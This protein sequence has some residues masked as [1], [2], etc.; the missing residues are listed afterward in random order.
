[1]TLTVFIVLGI[2]SALVLGILVRRLMA[3]PTGAFRSL[4]VAAVG[5]FALVP[6]VSYAL[7]LLGIDPGRLAGSEIVP[8]VMIALLLF[9]WLVLIQMSILLVI[10]LIIPTGTLTAALRNIRKLPAWWRRVRR[11]AEIQRILLRHGLGSYAKAALPVRRIRSREIAIALRDA[12]SAAGVTFIKLGQFMA[13]RADLVPPAYVEQ[14]K[15]LQADVPP[16]P[17]ENI[18]KVLRSQWNRPIDEVFAWFERTP[19][20]AASVAQVHRAR[21]FDGHDVVVKVQRPSV[22]A[23]VRADS[24]IILTLADR[25]ERSTEWGRSLGMRTIAEGFVESLQEELD[26]RGEARNTA[27]FRRDNGRA[28]RVGVPRVFADLSGE[29]VLVL[30]LLPGEPLTKAASLIESLPRRLRSELAEELFDVVARQILHTGIFHADLHGGNILVDK[31]GRTGLIDFGAVGR[32]DTRD[33]RAL[34]LLLMSFDKQNA[35]AATAALVDLLGA[36]EGLNL[37]EL[38][39]EVGQILMRYSS[40]LGESGA[41]SLFGEL[42]SFVVEFGLSLPAPVA[43]AFRAISALEGSLRLI[44]PEMDILEAVRRK[45]MSLMATATS[46]QQVADEAALYM[47]ANVPLLMRLPSKIAGLATQLQD[48]EV[49]VAPADFNTGGFTLMFK[50]L[51]EQL[52][53][54]V[55]AAACV[56]A[57]VLLMIPDFGPR[58]APEMGLFTYFGSLLLLV[59]LTL[60]A[61]VVS[62]MIGDRRRR[63]SQ[64]SYS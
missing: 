35:G 51:A 25:L 6:G 9:G 17:W 29:R 3:I 47:A 49:S 62:P 8:A 55:V 28:G 13:T 16:E 42:I 43:Q 18:E 2:V 57:G 41:S 50:S 64:P 40:G 34:A 26:Y 52:A 11:L 30:Q 20:A 45:G 21:T 39:R 33:R 19:M 27:M 58:L 10:E 24:E 44:D 5:G 22:R 12:L 53:Q 31:S 37:R 46:P 56:V 32:L 15:S 60:A 54:V 59:G 38:E 4:F 7:N 63:W 36:P 61:V 48:G 14:L 1:M 23:Q